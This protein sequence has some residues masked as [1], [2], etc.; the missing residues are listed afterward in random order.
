MGPERGSEHRTQIHIMTIVS[1]AIMRLTFLLQGA[2]FWARN[3]VTPDPLPV[4]F[5]VS[6]VLWVIVADSF[7]PVPLVPPR[8]RRIR[9]DFVLGDG[10]NTRTLC[11]TYAHVVCLEK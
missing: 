3:A 10:D 5:L 7:D 6:D 4:R 9:L 11:P 8:D 2:Y 1:F